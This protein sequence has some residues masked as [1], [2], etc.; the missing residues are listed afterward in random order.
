MKKL[1]TIYLITLSVFSATAQISDIIPDCA[2]GGSSNAYNAKQSWVY[3]G[4]FSFAP[5]QYWIDNY[6]NVKDYGVTGNGYTDDFQAVYDLLIMIAQQYSGTTMLYFP[7]GTYLFRQGGLS[8]PCNGVILKGAGGSF[9]MP[10]K[11]MFNFQFN[12]SFHGASIDISKDF[13]GIEDIY[14]VRNDYGNGITAG[15]SNGIVMTNAWYSWIRGVTSYGAWKNNVVLTNCVNITISGC[16]FNHAQVRGSGGEGYGI[17][18]QGTTHFCLIENNIFKRLRHAIVLQ[19][20]PQQNV[21]AY[22]YGDGSTDNL[23]F[24]M[25]D[26]EFHGHMG[27]NYIPGPSWNLIEGNKFRL[28]Q[29]SLVDENHLNNGPYNT[30]FR[31]DAVQFSI[32]K[33][34]YVPPIYYYEWNDFQ[35]TQNIVGSCMPPESDD[36]KNAIYDKGFMKYWIDNYKDMNCSIITDNEVCSD[37]PDD[38]CS[39]YMDIDKESNP[40]FFTTSDPWPFKPDAM[41]NCAERRYDWNDPDGI[42]TAYAVYAGWDLYDNYCGP[43]EKILNNYVTVTGNEYHY[44]MNSLEVSNYIFNSG[45]TATLASAGSV[46]LLPG[47]E[48]KAGSDVTIEIK[49]CVNPHPKS[50]DAKPKLKLCVVP[51]T[52]EQNNLSN[53]NNEAESLKNKLLTE[54]YFTVMPNPNNG[55]M[56]VN[57]EIPENETGTFEIYDIMGKKLYT[58]LLYSGKN[59]FAI[60]EESLSKGIYFYKVFVNDKVIASDKI[61]II[62]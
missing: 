39:Y 7:T 50:N 14:I 38:E 62:K 45:S 8:I 17:L 6:I 57:Y 49:P 3:S 61:V 60:T 40:D 25:P 23:N 5:G 2:L 18:L 28:I 21:I 53:N 32:T 30:F 47:F 16:Y 56:S 54:N 4:S 48:A 31:N 34:I 37:I 1:L 55:N 33:I 12:G 10:T 41:I 9:N 42:N 26:L 44:A 19:Q 52:E 36:V 22:N 58:Y 24:I 11:T 59:T 27:N 15:V 13:C 46:T 20:N 51:A 29:F 35:K 43:V